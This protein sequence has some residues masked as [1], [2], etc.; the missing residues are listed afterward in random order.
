MPAMRSG[1]LDTGDAGT[2]PLLVRMRTMR[3]I[4]AVAIAAAAALGLH[5]A[6]ADP[7]Q[8]V[9]ARVF[10]NAGQ[11]GLFIADAD[12]SDERL[13]LGAPGIDYDPVWSPDGASI[14]FTSDR[15]GSADLFRVKPD[16][17]GLERL[18]TNAAYDDQ[19]AFSPDGTQLVFV[20]TRGGGTRE[21]L[22]D[23]P[24]DAARAGR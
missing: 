17:T 22:D 15:E 20:T 23:G 14:V 24:A 12:G 13:L 21:P 1:D 9:F 19:A 3:T 5:A 6:G 18:T 16:G 11:I 4:L 8:I 10:P 7:Q 2:H